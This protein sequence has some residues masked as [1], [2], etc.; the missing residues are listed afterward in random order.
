MWIKT[1]GERALKYN[2]KWAVTSR[3]LFSILN[4]WNRKITEGLTAFLEVPGFLVLFKRPYFFHVRKYGKIAFVPLEDLSFRRI[5]FKVISFYFGSYI[6]FLEKGK[7]MVFSLVLVD[8][9]FL[10]PFYNDLSFAISPF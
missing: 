9:V 1:F 6:S 4:H 2:K 5:H 10:A 7:A 8:R 3:A